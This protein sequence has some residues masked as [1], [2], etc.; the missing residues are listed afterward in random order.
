MI[1]AI[2]NQGLVRFEFMECAMNTDRL[3]EFMGKLIQDTDKKVFL[4]LDNLR[5][6]HATLVT[7]WLAERTA[8]IEVFYLP[9]Y[10]PEINPDEYLNRD[11][12]TLLRTSARATTK[13]SLMDKAA[14]FMSFLSKTPER[15]R[16][17]FTHHDVQ[18]AA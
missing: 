18:Y 9:P 13:K 6:H 14:A 1:S 7:E 11:F 15:V 16:S 3:I 5:V 10:S 8:Q 17:Y 4:I 2:S 12:K